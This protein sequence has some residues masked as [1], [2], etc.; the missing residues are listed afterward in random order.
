MQTPL[1]SASNSFFLCVVPEGAKQT[2]NDEDVSLLNMNE[3]VRFSPPL[4]VIC[5]CVCV[6]EYGSN[7][8]TAIA[9]LVYD[10][11]QPHISPALAFV[12]A[13]LQPP[14]VP[15]NISTRETVGPL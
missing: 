6:C 2:D 12:R 8:C 1:V 10:C 13:R 9:P 11:V 15:F 14:Y 4:V 3:N 5:V 7:V